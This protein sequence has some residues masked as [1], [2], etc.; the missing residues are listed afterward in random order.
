MCALYRARVRWGRW[1]EPEHPDPAGRN[2]RELWLPALEWFFSERVDKL[3]QYE[4]PVDAKNGAKL[5]EEAA[6]AS[7]DFA[8]F[9]ECACM[10]TR[11]RRPHRT[12]T[13]T[14]FHPNTIALAD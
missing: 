13:A 1:L 8:I 4:K 9:I 10:H 3:C 5:S 14:T 12:T 11:T 2:M 7:A 6:L